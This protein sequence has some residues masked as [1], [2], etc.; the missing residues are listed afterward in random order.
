M[1]LAC[2]SCAIITVATTAALLAA[3]PATAVEPLNP[4]APC[5]VFDGA[6]CN[7][8]FC[9]V[10]GP[11]PCVP[12]LPSIGTSPRLTVHT[13]T[14]ESGRAPEGP[15]NSLRELF[16]ALRGCWEPPPLNEALP[17]MQMSVRFSFKRTG[18]LVAP[19]RVT[20]TSSGA[21]PDT[22]RVYG[23]A[24]DAALERCTPMPF[25][26][27]MGAAIAGRPIAVRFIDSRREN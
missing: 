27:E 16:A 6:P 18:E 25:G 1:G 13:R 3:D 10:F 9:G 20:Y 15:V 12:S 7:P 2:R 17:G 11:W 19:P 24:I 26:K 21:D 22:R 14:S 5:S 4:S 23:R 8:S